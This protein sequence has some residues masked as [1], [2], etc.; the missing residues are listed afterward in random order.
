MDGFEYSP[1]WCA[2]YDILVVRLDIFPERCGECKCAP[3]MERDVRN[4][5][6]RYL[7]RV[8]SESAIVVGMKISRFCQRESKNPISSRI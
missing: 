2:N 6:K 5:I 1:K 7:K 4:R 3:R 8:R